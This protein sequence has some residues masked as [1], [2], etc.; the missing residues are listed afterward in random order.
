MIDIK[1]KLLD[2]LRADA[3][4]MALLGGTP[5]DPRLYANYQRKASVSPD[6]PGFVTYSNI[7]MPEATMAVER[8]VYSFMIWTK[9]WTRAEQIAA[10]FRV[11]LHKQIIITAESKRLYTKVISQSDS[12]QEQPDFAGVTMHVRASWC[13][14]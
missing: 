5:A 1:D 13:N 3:Q 7:S 12:F 8:P 2:V 9:G 14:V 11:T 4:L 10:R 6:R